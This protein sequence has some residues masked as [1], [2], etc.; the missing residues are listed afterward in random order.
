MQIINNTHH[1]P[2]AS[3]F[4]CTETCIHT[5]TGVHK[6][7]S[8]D[9]RNKIINLRVEKNWFQR[10]ILL[11]FK[12][13]SSTIKDRLHCA[14]KKMAFTLALATR[15]VSVNQECL[16]DNRKDKQDIGGQQTRISTPYVRHQDDSSFLS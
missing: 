13:R 9:K 12:R 8:I 16:R 1:L 14:T 11:L 7:I 3:T 6:C 10:H 15:R 4:L 5:H 2:L